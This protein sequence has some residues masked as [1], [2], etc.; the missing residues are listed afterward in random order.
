[1]RFIPVRDLRIRPGEVWKMLSKE[2]NVI[3]TS[4]GRPKALMIEVDEGNIEESMAVLRRAKALMALEGIHRTAV[5]SG[6]S[7][8]TD[9]EIE[10]EIQAS[11]RAI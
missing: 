11:R 4:N 1:M 8:M 7:K 2:D 10:E 3:I 6:L 9:R 5:T